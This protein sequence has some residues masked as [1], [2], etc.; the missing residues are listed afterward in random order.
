MEIERRHFD[1]ID[2]TST[3]A[4]QN[5]HLLPRNKLTLV[6]AEGQTAGRGRFVRRRWISPPGLNIYASF[7]HFVDKPHDNW[8]NIPQVLAL[9]VVAV[10]EKMGFHPELKWP[11]D[12]KLSKKK[13]GGILAETTPVDDQI[14]MVVSVGLNINMTLESIKE[15]DQPATSL[16]AERGH[17]FDIEDTLHEIKLLY[18]KGIARFIEDGFAPFLEKYRKLLATSKTITVTNG[19][20]VWEGSFHDVNPDGSLILKLPNGE[21]KSFICGEIKTP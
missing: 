14:C 2:S 9:S 19:G 8:V 7:C 12:I 6:T 17:P 1:I 15:I 3:W 16:L 20:S 18:L 5:A 21:L 13:V 10:L 4:K 11:N